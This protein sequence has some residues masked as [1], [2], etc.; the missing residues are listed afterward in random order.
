[1]RS[2]AL[3]E[4]AM[5]F[6]VVFLR[7]RPL[8]LCFAFLLMFLPQISAAEELSQSITL[9]KERIQL[10][11]V[12]ESLRIKV[13]EQGYQLLKLGGAPE[14]PFRVVSI[15]LPQ[16]QAVYSSE[17]TARSEIVFKRNAAVITAGPLLAEDGSEIDAPNLVEKWPGNVFPES[18]GRYLGTAYLHGRTIA[19]FAVFPLRLVDRDLILAQTVTIEITTMPA[20]DDKIIFK[21]R[22]RSGSDEQVQ[23]L[24]SHLVV[25]PEANVRYKFNQIRAAEERGGFQPTDYPS[26]EGSAVDY[27]IVTN[28]ALASEY[29]RLA[30]W[31]TLKGVPTVVRTTEWIQANTRNGVDFQETLRFFIQD[32]Y[33]KW[34]ISYL[35]LGGDTDILPPRL[36]S[37]AYLLSGA[38]LAAD[39]YFGCLDGSWNDN[40]DENW[41]EVPEDNPDLYPEVYHGRIPLSQASEVS[42]MIDKI[43]SYESS[44]DPGYTDRALFLAE[45]LFPSDWNEGDPISLNGADL[46]ESLIAA[47]LL[48]LPLDMVRMY[49]SES[50]YPGS[51]DLNRQTALDSLN[52]GFNHVNYICHGSRSI[53]SAGDGLIYSDDADAL[54]N[55]DRWSNIFIITSSAAAFTYD[56][57]AEHFLSNADGGAVS[58][59]GNNDLAFL[60]AAN[61]Y[62]SEYYDVLFLEDIVHIGDAFAASRLPRT[63]LAISSNNVDTYHHYSYTLLADP[64]MPLFTGPVTTLDVAHVTSAGMGE[65]IILVNVS[66]GGSPVEAAVVCLSKDDDD[67]EV[68][69][70]DAL[71]DITVDFTAESPGSISVVV[72]GFNLARHQSYI[73]V[74]SSVTAF[75]NFD[76]LIIDDDAGGGSFGNGD[77]VVD[78]GETIDFTVRL[79]NTGNAPSD[80]V[81]L[82]LRSSATSVVVLDSI[83]E[84][85]VIAAGAAETALDPIRVALDASIADETAVEFALEIHDASAG[86]W[87]DTFKKI[88]HAPVLELI[89]LRINDDSPLGNGDGIIAPN[90]EFLL[91]YGIKNYGTGMAS[92]MSAVLEDVDNAFVFLDSTDIHPDLGALQF[93]ENL[94]GF[95]ISETDTTMEHLLRIAITDLVGHVYQDTFELRVPDPPT[96]LT[97]DASLGPY[98]LEIVWNG[99]PSPDALHYDLYRSQTSGGPYMI[100]NVDPLDHSMF[101]DTG[102]MPNSVYYYVA[103]TID[104]SGNRSVFSG[105]LTAATGPPQNAGFPIAGSIQSVSSPAVGDIDG[106]GDLEIVVGNEHVLAWHHDGTELIDGDGDP[107][108]SGVLNTLGDQFMAAV[109]LARL[110]GNP[111]LD[112]VAADI[113]TQSVYCMDYTGNALPGWPQT[114]ENDFRAAPSIGDLDGDGEFEVIAMDTKGVIY[115]WFADGTEFRDGDNNP[116]TSG[117]FFRTPPTTF[118]YQSPVLCDI[119]QDGLDE[120]IAGTRADT[121]YALNGDGSYVPGWPFAMPDELAGSMVAGDIDDYGLPELVA[122]A[123]SGEL[124]LLNHDG[125]VSPG[126]PKSVPTLYSFF[127]SSPAL[128][129]LDDDG[130]LEIVVAHNDMNDSRLY[131][132]NHDGS[133]YPGWPLVFSVDDY[134]E[135][136][137]VVADIDGDG[138]Q[139][140]ILGDEGGLISAWDRNGNGML[141]FPLFA[142]DPV[143]AAPMLDDIDGDGDIDMV[144]QSAD[145]NVYV[146][147][148]VGSYDSAESHWP[149][150]QGNVHH[151]GVFGF[152]VPTDAGGETTDVPFKE[153]A[154]LQNYPNPFNPVT[155]IVYLVPDGAQRSVTLVIYDVTGAR[156]RTLVNSRKAPGR[157][158][159]VWDA[160]NDAG[161]RVGSGVYFYRIEFEG[162]TA[163][164]KLVL[165]K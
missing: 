30:D 46:A 43:I 130:T 65:N 144:L 158:E 11:T 86:L 61:A 87:N 100:V 164:K 113:G 63:P 150:F 23:A 85:G 139:D 40:H 33:A 126:W 34:G 146:Y 4:Y 71:G 10:D 122:H 137:P 74:D 157:Y 73:A 138:S 60:A 97:A 48:G 104:M 136:S 55:A 25:N 9:S 70:T 29:Q 125:T 79:R 106:D 90:E 161:R 57:I 49:E 68:G 123:K 105:E 114:A 143:Q 119:D 22:F 35:L 110:D 53:L 76:D 66:A 62:M 151:N 13:H 17:V 128:A 134:T 111:G 165:L 36:A 115:A 109:A 38:G 84:F 152:L 59:I 3:E 94:S 101:L 108:T 19:S 102:L 127:A 64:E 118:H 32:A 16:G 95:H 27:L 72:S 147:D 132:I 88:V 81:W 92:S 121:V 93:G 56:C 142:G 51:V 96:S 154:L 77:G 21:E 44:D 163:T 83:A 153:A 124:Y 80:S 112:I 26:L 156:V 50:L 20:A 149:T 14:L 75:V 45:V 107:A 42:A 91:F 141:G 37:S 54:S 116:G 41:G 89:A 120:V 39:M 148:L 82:V 133:D 99:S 155:R 31:K 117:V 58:F 129:D 52:A 103:A 7:S 78:A 24:I 28:N 98:R 145:G 135:S 18:A 2:A 6:L 69:L 159:V 47:Y 15:L 131:V 1:M 140:L 67:Y 160:R 8:H 162:F 12:S 5:H